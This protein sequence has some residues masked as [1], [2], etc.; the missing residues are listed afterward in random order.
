MYDGEILSEVGFH[1]AA[2]EIVV[3]GVVDVCDHLRVVPASVQLDKVRYNQA[4]H[5]S[6]PFILGEDNIVGG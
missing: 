6:T 5:D 3:A 1:E 2:G 4:W